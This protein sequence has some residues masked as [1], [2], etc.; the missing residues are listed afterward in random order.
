MSIPQF[1]QLAERADESLKIIDKKSQ[2]DLSLADV[3]KMKDILGL[4]SDN[5]DATNVLIGAL[6]GISE[7]CRCL[8]LRT[9]R[10]MFLPPGPSIRSSG[11]VRCTAP[12]PSKVSCSYCHET[13]VH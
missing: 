4:L 8:L 12:A 10:T 7:V 9:P 3:E 2:A 5:V 1:E 13:H 11:S 6:K